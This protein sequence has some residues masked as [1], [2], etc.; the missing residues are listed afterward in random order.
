MFTWFVPPGRRRCSG[1]APS[2]GRDEPTREHVVVCTALPFADAGR[3]SL[4]QHNGPS[5]VLGVEQTSLLKSYLIV[6]DR[7]MRLEESMICFNLSR[8]GSLGSRP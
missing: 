6:F 8:I 2:P 7:D 3:L 1:S 4:G 5:E